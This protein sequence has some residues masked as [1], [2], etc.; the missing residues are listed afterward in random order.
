[1]TMLAGAPILA[2][3]SGQVTDELLDYKLFGPVT[4]HQALLVVCGLFMIVLFSWAARNVRA[5]PKRTGFVELLEFGLVW[6]RDEIVY[7]WLGPDRGRT[8]LPFLWTIFFF[9]LFSNL[10]GLIPWPFYPDGHTDAFV[11]ATG[12]L[13]VTAALAIMVFLVVQVS[14]MKEQG[15]FKYWKSLV[16]PGVPTAIWPL[17]FLVEFMGQFTRHFALTVRLFANMLAGHALFAILFGY[18]IWIRHFPNPLGGLP[19]TV[20]SV[21]FIIFTMLFEVLI[22]LVQAYLFTVLTAIF[23][24]LAVAEA[25]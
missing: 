5:K 14:G 23:V 7:P 6:V 3:E 15:V 2:A 20:A 21:G 17:V 18:L 24:S 9:V 16:P 4:A 8:Y 1:M 10:F 13:A 11:V 12:N 22:A 19:E 25:H